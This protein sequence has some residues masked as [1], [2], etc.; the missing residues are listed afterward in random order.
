M[1]FFIAPISLF[2]QRNFKS[3]ISLSQVQQ[4]EDDLFKET[5]ATILYRNVYLKFGEILEVREAKKIYTKDGLDYGNWEIPYEDVEIVEANTYNVDSEGNLIVTPVSK[6]QIFT[7]ILEEGDIST[8]IAF[9]QVKV[10]SVVELIYSVKD[11]GVWDISYQASIPIKEFKLTLT[12]PYDFNITISKNGYSPVVI[13]SK[14]TYLGLEYVGK[15]IPALQKDPFLGSFDNYFGRLH[16]EILMNYRW[17]KITTWNDIGKYYH[18]IGW[19]DDDKWASPRRNFTDLLDDGKFFKTELNRIIGTE[20]DPL[21]KAKKIY[22]FVRDNMEW[23]NQY[24]YNFGKKT[25][26]VYKNKKGSS[27]EIN[28]ILTTMLREAGLKANLM[29]VASKNKGFIH[30]LTKSKFNNVIVC[31]EIDNRD[32]L[33]DASRKNAGFG[34][35]PLFFVNGDGLVIYNSRVSRLVNTQISQKS[36]SISSVDVMLD[37]EN[38]ILKGS[39]KKRLSGYYAWEK[40]NEAEKENNNKEEVKEFLSISN[41]LVND[42]DNKNGQ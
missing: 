29:L 3:N 25:K 31:L 40:R 37:M 42:L 4:T 41:V 6:N 20:T 11:V 34:E 5:S 16:F 39:V 38:M 28:V 21:E 2:G 22:S 7:E 18:E 27:G 23:D 32:I 33:L 15:N 1:T 14:K 19:T 35:L 13:D 9:P 30:Y 12:N 17:Q 36:H 10:G 8:K 24:Y 26:D